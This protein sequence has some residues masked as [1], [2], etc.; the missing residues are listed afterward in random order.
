MAHTPQLTVAR[1][2]PQPLTR[3]EFLELKARSEHSAG[4]M[5]N[6]I[7]RKKLAET[8]NLFVGRCQY[9]VC[10][11]RCGAAPLPGFAGVFA[12]PERETR[13]RR[14]KGLKVRPK[15]KREGTPRR[16]ESCPPL[17]KYLGTLGREGLG[18]GIPQ[19][20]VEVRS[21]GRGTL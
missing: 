9:R 1:P 14:A 20:R 7:A 3:T 13:D 8:S 17:L 19:R 4:G 6:R 2:E 15:V 18:R 21:G 5:D 10:A 11:C 16:R 12:I